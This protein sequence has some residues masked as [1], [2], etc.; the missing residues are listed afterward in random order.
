LIQQ[1]VGFVQLWWVMALTDPTWRGADLDPGT[2]DT[3]E[4][5]G[6]FFVVLLEDVPRLF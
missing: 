6:S 2:N 1:R 3:G 4:R 5:P